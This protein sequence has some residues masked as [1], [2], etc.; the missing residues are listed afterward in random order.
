MN[1]ISKRILNLRLTGI[2]FDFTQNSQDEDDGV[3]TQIWTDDEIEKT[4]SEDEYSLD[5]YEEVELNLLDAMIE[6]IDCKVSCIL[7]TH[8]LASSGSVDPTTPPSGSKKRKLLDEQ[9]C[10]APKKQKKTL[11]VRR[12]I[13]LFKEDISKM[14]EEHGAGKAKRKNKK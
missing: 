2:E 10:N 14:K 11:G 3:Q 6:Y 1:G 13:N 5:E 7:Q 4:V 8:A 9:L 12:P